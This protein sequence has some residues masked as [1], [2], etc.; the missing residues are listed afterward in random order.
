MTTLTFLDST[1]YYCLWFLTFSRN[2]LQKAEPLSKT[3]LQPVA[4]GD[5]TATLVESPEDAT[6]TIGTTETLATVDDV[7]EEP[8][9]EVKEEDRVEVKVGGCKEEL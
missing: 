5:S 4:E 8:K 7:V 3:E 6:V 9:E 2:S 1:L